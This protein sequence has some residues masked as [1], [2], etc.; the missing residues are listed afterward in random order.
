MP[1]RGNQAIRTLLTKQL[2]ELLRQ[3]GIGIEDIVFALQDACARRVVDL[4][5]PLDPLAVEQFAIAQ[6]SVEALAAA[7]LQIVDA[8]RVAKKHADKLIAERKA[9]T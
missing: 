6:A 3:D 5:P 9:K 2:H 7:R 1:P 4:A 8:S